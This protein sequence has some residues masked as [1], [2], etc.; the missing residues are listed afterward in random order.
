MWPF[1]KKTVITLKDFTYGSFYDALMENGVKED[2]HQIPDPI[3]RNTQIK[4]FEKYRWAAFEQHLKTLSSE[5]QKAFKDKKHPSQSHGLKEAAE[6]VLEELR[7]EL[8]GL[9]FIIGVNLG[10]HQ[11]GRIV[12]SILLKADCEFD[13]CYKMLPWLYKGFETKV[14]QEE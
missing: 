11:A 5:E 8:K 12:F 4:L 14:S 2:F 9:D 1:K 6:I 7:E 3:E 10:L 13:D